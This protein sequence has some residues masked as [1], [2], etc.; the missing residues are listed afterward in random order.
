MP[1]LEI[2][3]ATLADEL[4]THLWSHA[5]YRHFE[6]AIT[7]HNGTD[8]ESGELTF[9]ILFPED[10]VFDFSGMPWQPSHKHEIDNDVYDVWS[11]APG[12]G[13]YQ[14][15]SG[16]WTSPGGTWKQNLTVNLK[17]YAQSSLIL[18][19]LFQDGDPISDWIKETVTF[20]PFA[21]QM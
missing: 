6:M 10:I 21:P 13:R 12:I 20:K 8:K 9:E 7:I 11:T 14:S 16:V 15:S 2:S 17:P 1:G 5:P 4:R 19:R 18:R 3:I